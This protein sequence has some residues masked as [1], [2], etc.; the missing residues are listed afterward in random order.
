MSPGT[1]P[2]VSLLESVGTFANHRRASLVLDKSVAQTSE[3]LPSLPCLSSVTYNLKLV[4]LPDFLGEVHKSFKP[5][6]TAG[7]WAVRFLTRRSSY[8]NHVLCCLE[9]GRVGGGFCPVSIRMEWL[10]RHFPEWHS[11]QNPFTIFCLS[12][13]NLVLCTSRHTSI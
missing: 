1:C 7:D 13:G 6:I 10:Y 8:S 12:P 2:S 4:R 9:G 5:R 11:P 3:L